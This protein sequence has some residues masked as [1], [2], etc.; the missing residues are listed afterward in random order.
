MAV[1]SAPVVLFA[2]AVCGPPDAN[3]FFVLTGVSSPLEDP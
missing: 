3:A 2:D 1:A